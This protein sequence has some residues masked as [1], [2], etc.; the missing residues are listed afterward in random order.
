M[1]IDTT[2]PYI[3]LKTQESELRI[4]LIHYFPVVLISTHINLELQAYIDLIDLQKA[5]TNSS[6]TPAYTREFNYNRVGF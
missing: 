6:L 1:R 3:T 4:I 5:K 2:S